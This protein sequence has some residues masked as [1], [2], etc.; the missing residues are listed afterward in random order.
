MARDYGI[1]RFWVQTLVI[2]FNTEGEAAFEPH[3]RRPRANPR[4]VSLEVEVPRSAGMFQDVEAD[5]VVSLLARLSAED[6]RAWVAGGWAVDAL[7][8]RPTRRHHDLDLAVDAEQLDQILAVLAG[9]GYAPREDWLPV[10][11]ELEDGGRRVD[12]HPLR[13]AQDG[14][15]VQAGLDDA[16]FFYASDAF[17]TGRIAGRTVRCLTARQQLEFRMG[18]AWRDVDEHDVALLRRW[19]G[20]SNPEVVE[21]VADIEKHLREHLGGNLVGLYIFGSVASG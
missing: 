2:R 21:L 3:S 20:L 19:I 12:L 9:L 15:A 5:D 11:I 8:G 13:F 10:R 18:Y 17:T 6:V 14:S 7:L 16:E 1:C 4:A